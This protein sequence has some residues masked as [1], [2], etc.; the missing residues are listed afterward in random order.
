MRIRTRTAAFAVAATTSLVGAA[1]TASPAAATATTCSQD[2]VS[3]LCVSSQDEQD[4]LAINYQIT[5][6]DG[7]GTYSLFDVST[8]TGVSSAPH[9]IGPLAYQGTASGDLYAGLTDCYNVY[10]TSTAGTS[11]VAGPV[12]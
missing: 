4:V 1:L 7:P 3:T 8:T 5:Q 6:T 2:G 10:L 9:T 11:L 12:C